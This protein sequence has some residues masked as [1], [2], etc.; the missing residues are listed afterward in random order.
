[1]GTSWGVKELL[2]SVKGN[3]LGV[4]KYSDAEQIAI[5]DASRLT[6]MIN[7][8][9]DSDALEIY[10]SGIGSTFDVTRLS[11]FLYRE[12]TQIGITT[13]KQVTNTAKFVN[14][15]G[16]MNHKLLVILEFLQEVSIAG[17]IEIIV[18]DGVSPITQTNVLSSDAT[19]TDTPVTYVVDTSSFVEDVE[20]V[21]TISQLQV[22]VQYLELRGL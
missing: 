21:V 8:N 18:T 20:L 17:E 1:M 14:S 15:R 16:K 3:Q 9:T 4:P 13:P 22:A 6:G 7:Y 2:E 12:E 5:I 10:Q 19:P 11:N